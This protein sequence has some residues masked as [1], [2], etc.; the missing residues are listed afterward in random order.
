MAPRWTAAEKTQLLELFR[1]GKNE[2]EI[3]A[4]IGRTVAGVINQRHMG[5]LRRLPSGRIRISLGSPDWQH[6][7]RMVVSEW[8]TM[9]DGTRMRTV[10]G[11]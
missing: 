1:A 5:G 9:P 3:A 7:T 6:Q 4:A 11:V 2:P 10:R 8:I